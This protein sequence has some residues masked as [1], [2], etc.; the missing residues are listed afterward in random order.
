MNGADLMGA[1][2]VLAG[3]SPDAR[4]HA[5]IIASRLRLTG[6]V[7]TLRWLQ[8]GAQRE[9]A[10]G[11]GELLTRLEAELGVQVARL[12][13]IDTPSLVRLQDR[14]SRLADALHVLVRAGRR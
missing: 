2:R 8:I 12:D 7:S 11:H 6:L 9:R 3:L 5:E 1:E 10:R 14:A 4:G 13:N